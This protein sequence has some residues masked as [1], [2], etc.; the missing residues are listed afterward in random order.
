MILYSVS[1]NNTKIHVTDNYL[2]AQ[3]VEKDLRED[4]F[5]KVGISQYHSDSMHFCIRFATNNTEW[6]PVSAENFNFSVHRENWK[7]FR[8]SI[9]RWDEKQKNK[10][11]SYCKLY[12]RMHILCLT[13]SQRNSLMLDMVQKEEFVNDN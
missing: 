10:G 3:L 11:R 13:K 4:G 5:K 1:G 2:L 6:I 9:N 7:Y 12:G 8:E